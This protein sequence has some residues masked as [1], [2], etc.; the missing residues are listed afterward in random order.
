MS[1]AATSLNANVSIVSNMADLGPPPSALSRKRSLQDMKQQF[2]A[3]PPPSSSGGTGSGNPRFSFLNKPTAL[4]KANTA[5][6]S[7]NMEKRQTSDGSLGSADFVS[8]GGNSTSNN[9]SKM[10]KSSSTSNISSFG[11]SNNSRSGAGAAPKL[12][13]HQFLGGQGGG[14][15]ASQSNGSI[16]S[17]SALFKSGMNAAA[18]ASKQP[19]LQAVNLLEL[20][21]QNKKK[22]KS[23]GKEGGGGAN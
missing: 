7:I 17:M 22:R 23:L 13:T 21:R 4:N 10:H 3:P 8:F 11:G 9:T 1:M 12:F 20:E 16:S 18:A 2:S 19:P 5:L 14:I 6:G 15:K